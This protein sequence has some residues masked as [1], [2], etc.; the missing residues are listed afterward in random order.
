MILVVSTNKRI[1]GLQQCT[2]QIFYCGSRAVDIA[3]VVIV[4]L[5]KYHPEVVVVFCFRPTPA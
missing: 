4:R 1:C 5:C 3:Q 2:M